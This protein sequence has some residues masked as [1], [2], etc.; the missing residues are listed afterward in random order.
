LAELGLGRGIDINIACAP[1]GSTFLHMF[2]R[3]REETIA[4]EA[5]KWFLK[6]GADPKRERADGETPLSL[7][8]KLGRT[9]LVMIMQSH[10]R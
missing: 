4:A 6:H 10:S 7:A 1:D 3:I 2:A 8:T 9:K 5:I